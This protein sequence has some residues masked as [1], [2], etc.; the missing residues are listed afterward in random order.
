MIGEGDEVGHHTQNAVR[1]EFQ[2]SGHSRNHLRLHGGHVHEDLQESNQT[3][4][5]ES[6]TNLPVITFHFNFSCA[7]CPQL[8]AGKKNITVKLLPQSH[9]TAR[10][11]SL[12]I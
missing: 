1:E 12:K 3:G 10:T 9:L 4:Q 6:K 5:E 8:S 7:F 11:A 2:V